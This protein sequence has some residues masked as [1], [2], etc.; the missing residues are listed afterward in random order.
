[1]KNPHP[2]AYNP[3]GEWPTPEIPTE[4]ICPDCGRHG[5]DCP[6]HKTHKDNEIN[7]LTTEANRARRMG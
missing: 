6:E 1:M 4:D 3:T 5:L 2:F 7:E